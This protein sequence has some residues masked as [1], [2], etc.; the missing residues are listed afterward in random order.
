M[1]RIDLSKIRR[2]PLQGHTSKGDQPKWSNGNRWY[3]ADYMG[4]ESLA[5]VLISRL[6]KQSN[7]KEY[8]IYEPVMICCS[9][10]ESVGCVSENFRKEKEMLI[11]FERLHRA[12]QGRGLAETLGRIPDVVQR[13]Q[14]TVDF[15]ERV[16]ELTDIGPYLTMLLELDRLFLNEDRH[17][18][19]LAVLRDEELPHFRLCPVFDNGLSLLSDLHDYPLG[20]DV[21]SYIERIEAKPFARDFDEQTEA[22]EELYGTQLKVYFTKQD[23][24]DVLDELSEYYSEAVLRRVEQVLYEQIRKYAACLR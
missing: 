19:N 3:K 13:I 12:Y 10:T 24:A 2:E 15:V 6:L 14:Y 20:G 22:S 7:V 11:S 8:V 4:Y 16:T 9:G 1:E 18:N 23:A 21:Y 17:T 5:E